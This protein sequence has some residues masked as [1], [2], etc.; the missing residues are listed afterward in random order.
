MMLCTVQGTEFNNY[1]PEE[2]LFS[3]RVSVSMCRWIV[4]II[5]FWS[6]PLQLKQIGLKERKK[7]HDRISGVTPQTFMNK[8]VRSVEKYINNIC[9]FK[10]NVYIKI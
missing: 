3:A 9:L 6:K 10:I 8:Q 2:F 1:K 4:T 5:G 7:K